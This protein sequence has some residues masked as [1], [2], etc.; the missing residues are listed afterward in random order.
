V[1]KGKDAAVLN[2]GGSE[3]H[4]E[5]E[6][7]EEVNL[8]GQTASTH[9][10]ASGAVG[11]GGSVTAQNV[12]ESGALDD[13][14]HPVSPVSSTTRSPSFKRPRNRLG[15]DSSSSIESAS[16]DTPAFGDDAISASG[17]HAHP[18]HQHADPGTAIESETSGL[19]RPNSSDPMLGVNDVISPT[20]RM[21]RPSIP[22]QSHPSL[23]GHAYEGGGHDTSASTSASTSTS[24]SASG[25]ASAHASASAATQVEGHSLSGKTAKPS[26]VSDKDDGSV[27]VFKAD[28]MGVLE[29]DVCTQLLFEPVTTPCQH[30]SVVMCLLGDFANRLCE[31]MGE[32]QVC[33]AD[34]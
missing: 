11:T 15:T 7:E 33:R 28:L 13:I 22:H 4:G 23:A 8:G 20:D 2:K 26:N 19:G 5:M 12:T 27:E 18:G 25:S 24:T 31:V 3:D 10:A 34:V 6:V 30:V 14:V 17:S 9:P 1:D 21:T 16:G 29:C 32:R